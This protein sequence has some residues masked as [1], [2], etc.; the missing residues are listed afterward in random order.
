MFGLIFELITKIAAIGS[1]VIALLFFSNDVWAQ[2]NAYLILS[3][4]CMLWSQEVSK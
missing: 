4:I 1:F 2:G 3:V